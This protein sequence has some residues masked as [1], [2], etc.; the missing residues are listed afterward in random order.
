LRIYAAELLSSIGDK[1]ASKN[2]RAV[3]END[4]NCRVR[5][6]AKRAYEQI[7]GEEFEE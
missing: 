1:R 7:S 2:L 3:G 6:D 4:G 5:K